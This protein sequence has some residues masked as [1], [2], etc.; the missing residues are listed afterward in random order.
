MNEQ[1]LS[2]CA[3]FVE[4]TP[5]ELALVVAGGNQYSIP[6]NHLFFDMDV[7]NESLFVVLSG[8]V[9]IERPGT[10]TNIELATLGSGA[11]FGEMSFMDG[12]KTTA[13]VSTVEATEV[14]ELHAKDFHRILADRPV[15]ASKL[16]R[17][18]ALEFRRRIARTNE[19][20]DY[21]ADLS[22]VLRD[23]PGAASLLGV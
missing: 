22:Q 13:Q 3:L 1:A 16:W 12:S 10:E 4:L 7:S 2:K 18:L 19:L 6:E 21:Y 20:V 17:N 15:L 9:R 11:I 5:D 14:L 23:N 8:S